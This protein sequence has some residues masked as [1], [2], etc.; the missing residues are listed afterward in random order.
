MVDAVNHPAALS[1]ALPPSRDLP[2]H[3]Q[4]AEDLGYERVWAYDSPSLYG[5]IW[6]A[7]GRAAEATTTIGLATGVA[8]P[9]LR[10][11]M[12]TAS[13]IASIEELAP[14]RLVAAFGTG[15]TGRRA[16]GGPRCAGRTS[17]PT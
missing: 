11:V 15:F 10:H 12:V 4:V 2:T 14:G 8:I 9:S 5:D 16:M 6:L 1:C 13:A 17:P 7:L 3:A